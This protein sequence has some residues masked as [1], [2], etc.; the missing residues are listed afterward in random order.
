[1][2]TRAVKMVFR[3]S[4]KDIPISSIKSM[5]GESFSASGAFN[6]AAGLGA[7]QDNFLPPTINYEMADKRCDLDIVPNEMRE[8]KVIKVLINAFSPTGNNSCLMIGK[9]G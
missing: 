4:A 5:V 1:M 7:I 8:K 9:A 2:E 3:D 6:L